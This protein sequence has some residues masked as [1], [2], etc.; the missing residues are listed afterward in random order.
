MG[1]Q[2][3]LSDVINGSNELNIATVW[4]AKPDVI[5]RR[6]VWFTDF[7]RKPRFWSKIAERV[8][9]LEKKANF[10]SVLSFMFC[11]LLSAHLIPLKK[12][13][14]YLRSGSQINE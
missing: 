2:K 1:S 7:Q 13:K 6:L 3:R 10:L 5:N 8:A 4:N 14:N 11:T 9:E 12:K